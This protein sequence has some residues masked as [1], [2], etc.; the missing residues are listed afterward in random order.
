ML[1]LDVSALVHEEASEECLGG[2]GHV[3]LH[4]MGRCWLSWKFQCLQPVVLQSS[5][6][7]SGR[8]EFE[9][10][11]IRHDSGISLDQ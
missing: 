1:P 3:A 5:A 8:G 4:S 6:V 7:T 2:S 10:L 9:Q 11:V